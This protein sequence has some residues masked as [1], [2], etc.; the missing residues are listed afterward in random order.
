MRDA[1]ID[2]PSDV[3]FVQIKCPLA[4]QRADRGGARRGHKTVTTSGYASMG[5]S[6]GA[7]ALGVAVALGELDDGVDEGQVL[8]DWESFSSVASSSA[9]IEL[10]HNVV[11]VMGNSLLS[12]SPFVIGHARDARFDRS[13]RGARGVQ[14]RRAWP[15][16]RAGRMD[17]W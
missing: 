11:I 14:E 2:D 1:G 6:R 9:G 10:M 5:Y 13:S 12:T 8:K 16:R 7:S 17:G 3:H 4:D 15:G